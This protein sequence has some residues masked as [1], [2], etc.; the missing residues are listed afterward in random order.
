[1]S[2]G[3]VKKRGSTSSPFRA[4]SRNWGVKLYALVISVCA[5]VAAFSIFA[6]VKLAQS[7]A[8]PSQSTA[9]VSIGQASILAERPA[10]TPKPKVI[11]ERQERKII[12]TVRQDFSAN[13]QPVFEP[14]RKE[15]QPPKPVVEE[16]PATENPTTVAEDFD[17]PGRSVEFFDSRAEGRRICYVVDCSGSMQGLWGRVKA[18]LLESIGR[19][20]P[21]Q[22]FSVIVFGGGGILESG[23]GLLVRATERA[24]KDAYNLIEAVWPRGTT[25]AAAALEYAIK[26]RDRSD[27][28][29]SVIYF[30]T[31]GFELN[32]QDNARFAHQVAT[33]RNGF[34]PQTR[35]HTIGF[36]PDEQDKKLLETIA[37]ESG[38]HFTLV[39]QAGG[40]Q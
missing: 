1:M 8:I 32:R 11:P 31:D 7:P 6:A 18:E 3:T 25:N 33:M 36:W 5:H 35:I 24:K 28:G 21:D 12:E 40:G 13:I 30:L 23:G 37:K 17:K 27:A 4:R 22:Y 9:I 19:L 20:Q 34:S 15:L 29:S 10:V 14:A 38:G 26:I 39:E 2:Q 16:D